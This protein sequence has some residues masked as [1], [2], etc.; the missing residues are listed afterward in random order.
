MKIWID[1]DA[2]PKTVK[3]IIFRAAQR[4]K[5]ETCLVANHDMQI[6]RSSLISKVLVPKGFDVADGYIVEHLGPFDLVITADIPLAAEVVESEA[7][8]ISPRGELYTTEN[9]RERLSVRNFMQD[10]RDHGG[11]TGGPPPLKESDKRQ[12]AST[13]DRVLTQLRRSQSPL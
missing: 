4:L 1:A 6:P 5:I 7:F 9:V 12:F 10:I 8:A 3:E 11:S 2:C 13:F